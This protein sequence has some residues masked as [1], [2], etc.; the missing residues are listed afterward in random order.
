[1]QAEKTQGEEEEAHQQPAGGESQGPQKRPK[2]RNSGVQTDMVLSSLSLNPDSPRQSME[3]TPPQTPSLHDLVFQMDATTSEQLKFQVGK[4]QGLLDAE[5]KI[6]QQ[7]LTH[8]KELEQETKEL[9]TQLAS[10]TAHVAS[11]E[12]SLQINGNT[13]TMLNTKNQ[14]LFREMSQYKEAAAVMGDLH[15]K[16]FL[17][18]EDEL[19]QAKIQIVRLQSGDAIQDLARKEAK[20]AANLE[21]VVK[22]DES[23]DG[24]LACY[25]CMRTIRD[26][27]VVIPCGHI[28]CFQCFE[29]DNPDRGVVD[30]H[31]YEQGA[32]R[33]KVGTEVKRVVGATVAAAY[34]F[35]GECKKACVET[36]CRLP[37]FDEV[38]SKQIFKT[39]VYVQLKRDMRVKVLDTSHETAAV[40][41]SAGVDLD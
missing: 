12:E 25:T 5:R 19:R 27:V 15:S 35:C 1:M 21:K 18:I 20:L 6:N 26:A 7:R 11:L 13:I 3:P 40:P 8:N 37:I 30:T 38:I 24:I 16:S 34:Y 17:S 32:W 36:Y 9:K 4:L 41:E 33:R 22:A 14:Q 29:K 28:F 23:I 39:T 31:V 2:V 10:R